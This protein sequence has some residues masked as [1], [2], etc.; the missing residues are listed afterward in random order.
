LLQGR[1]GVAVGH[2][3][4]H[5]TED[6][7]GANYMAQRGMDSEG[8]TVISQDVSTLTQADLAKLC[9]GTNAG[10]HAVEEAFALIRI[11]HEIRSAPE[12]APR[13]VV[14]EEST[15]PETFDIREVYNVM[16]VGMLERVEAKFD[17]GKFVA[18]LDALLRKYE[19]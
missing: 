5:G 7:D 10:K 12:I 16:A 18:E 13:P 11:L 1:F 17:R 8:I 15:G 19:R 4:H 14:T 9:K 2:H 6:P 3:I